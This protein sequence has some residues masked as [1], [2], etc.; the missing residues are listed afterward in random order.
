MEHAVN[1]RVC[2]RDLGSGGALWVLEQASG[3]LSALFAYEHAARVPPPR[4]PRQPRR[5][6]VGRRAHRP[7]RGRRTPG[8]HVARGIQVDTWR[9]LV[10]CS[11]TW[12]AQACSAL[13]HGLVVAGAGLEPEGLTRSET[14]YAIGFDGGPLDP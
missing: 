1:R 14:L 6:S 13:L 7:T 10:L 12:R 9:V 8:R 5:V 4:Q 3:A 2:A 11:T